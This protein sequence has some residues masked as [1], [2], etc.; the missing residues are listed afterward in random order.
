MISS[1]QQLAIGEYLAK[2]LKMTYALLIKDEHKRYNGAI[3]K[4]ILDG[5]TLLSIG[6]FTTLVSSIMELLAAGH[7]VLFAI[8]DCKCDLWLRD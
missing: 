1:P 4:R 8:K 5:L 7:W 2:H 3:E 6:N